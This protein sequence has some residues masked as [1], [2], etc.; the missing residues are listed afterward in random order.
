MIIDGG[1]VG[2]NRLDRGARLAARL[3]S[4]VQGALR[5]IFAPAHHAADFA[6]LRIHAYERRLC[7]RA[8]CGRVGKARA[9]FKQCVRIRLQIFIKARVNAQSARQNFIGGQCKYL[10][11]FAQNAVHIP[12]VGICIRIRHGELNRLRRGA[13]FFLL[14][15]HAAGFHH[16][17]HIAAPLLR[18]IGVDVRRVSDRRFDH[19]RQQRGLGD[20]QLIR[21]LGIIRLRGGLDPVCARAEIHGVDVRFQNF[22][23]IHDPLQP[24]RQNRFARLAANRF[25]T[26]QVRQFNQ[27]L[28]DGG[29]ALR[30][31]SR[32]DIVDHRAE[33]AMYVDAGMIVESLIFRR[34]K[35]VRY[36]FGQRIDGYPDSILR[37]GQRADALALCIVDL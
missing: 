6:G 29:S 18:A 32:F 30:K 27:L 7:G 28:R 26:G 20:R 19:A 14:R 36:I 3:R 10:L 17:K 22:P 12:A 5:R 21:A 15:D 8:V 13:F 16:G 2:G 1:G 25:F 23:L 37:A 24:E 34:D 31:R 35:G 33:Y 4:A 11:R 9:V